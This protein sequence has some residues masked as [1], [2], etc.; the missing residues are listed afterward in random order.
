MERKPKESILPVAIAGGAMVVCCLAPALLV[1]GA[2]GL[3]AWLGG[4]D[5]LLA[6]AF[7]VAMGAAVVLFR[8]MRQSALTGLKRSPPTTVSKGDQ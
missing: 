8:R 5:P 1:S 3:A 2:S 6:V 7:A 4:I